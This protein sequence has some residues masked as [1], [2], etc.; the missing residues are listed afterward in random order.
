LT[1]NTLTLVVQVNGKLRGRIEV[2]SDADQATILTM[3]RDEPQVAK[4]LEGMVEKKAI[5]VPQKLVNLVV[6]PV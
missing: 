5:V 3:A 4:F 2:P 1:R 6:A